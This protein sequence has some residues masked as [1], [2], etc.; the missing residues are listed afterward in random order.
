FPLSGVAS[1]DT[2]TSAKPWSN[3]SFSS[4]SYGGNPLAAAAGLAALEIIL[5]ED[6]VK[7]AERVGKV[8]LARLEQMKEKHR[9]VG[10]VRGKGLL[11][12]RRTKEPLSRDVTRTLYQECLRRGLVAMSYAPTIRIN[13][14]LVIRE[15]Q[16]LAGLAILDEAL[17]V[18][19]RQ[20]GLS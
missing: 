10:E 15:D 5:K 17:E 20:H 1:S 8:M 11:K 9:V 18:V 16:A 7:N 12:D 3:P 4:S 19:T 13:P 14:P 2:V 6:L